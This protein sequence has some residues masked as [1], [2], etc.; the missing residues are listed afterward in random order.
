MSVVDKIL[1]AGIVLL[2]TITVP[3]IGQSQSGVA[4]SPNAN[5][6]NGECLYALDS[7]GNAVSFEIS[8]ASGN[9]ATITTLGVLG[10]SPAGTVVGQYA[11][12]RPV[13]PSAFAA[14]LRYFGD[15]SGGSQVLTSGTLTLTSDLYLESLSWSSGSTG[16]LDL[17]GFNLYVAGTLDMSN[18]PAGGIEW[19]SLTKGT[20]GAANGN[21]GAGCVATPSGTLGGSAPGGNGGSSVATVS[22]NPGVTGQSGN[23]GGPG[24][25]GGAGGA[26]DGGVVPGGAGGVAGGV[27][28]V[29]TL[30]SWKKDILY[31]A[32]LLLGGGTGGGG[33]GAGG[34][35]AAG[36]GA[37]GSGGGQGGGVMRINACEFKTGASTPANAIQNIGGGSN[38]PATPST[39]ATGG[40][41]GAGAGGGGC[42]ILAIGMRSG[43]TVTNLIYTAGNTG[44]TGGNG[45]TTGTG[46]TG[47]SGGYSGSVYTMNLSALPGSQ[48]NYYAPVAGSAGSAGSGT[49]GG[50]GGAGGMLQV[51]F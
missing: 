21:A 18:A 29:L 23:L 45:L 13:H 26:G 44:G 12:C 32:T 27:T 10:N 17:A 9:T 19:N 31:G 40:G 1:G 20:A 7:A 47:G 15:G 39:N 4:F 41:G 5:L 11:T 2:S 42:I 6:Y 8:S 33:G 28:N 3:S 38:T 30:R 24:G 16:L 51:S 35:N 25:A 22:G 49:T 34:N 48:I 36:K 50:P 43:P 14:A 37:G 46:G